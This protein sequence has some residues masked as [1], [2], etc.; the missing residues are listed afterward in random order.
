MLSIK[1]V[2]NCL[3]MGMELELLEM[4]QHVEMAQIALIGPQAG[5]GVALLQAQSQLD[6]PLRMRNQP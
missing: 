1:R 2:G 5:Y 6:Q 3:G 4:E